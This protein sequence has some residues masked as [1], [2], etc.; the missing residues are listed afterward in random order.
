VRV[1]C[2]EL[3]TEQVLACSQLGIESLYRSQISPW[4]ISSQ[5]FGSSGS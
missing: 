5:S 4:L 2:T 1:E 3:L